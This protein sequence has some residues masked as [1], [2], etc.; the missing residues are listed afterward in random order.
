MQ[1][2]STG[3][4]LELHLPANTVIVDHE[5]KPVTQL[6]ITAIPLDC[7]NVYRT[8]HFPV[9]TYKHIEQYQ[10]EREAAS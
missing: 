9:K 3:T 6:T 4:D 5:G 10:E 2:H 7:G 8:L 1:I